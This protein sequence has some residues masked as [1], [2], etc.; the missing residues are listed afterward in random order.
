MGPGGGA[1]GTKTRPLKLVTQI[2]EII[3]KG[4][5]KTFAFLSDVSA[6]GLDWGFEL[7]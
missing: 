3:T 5:P 1:F 2:N 4:S 6:I 7:Y